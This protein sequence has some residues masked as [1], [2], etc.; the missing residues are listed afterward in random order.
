REAELSDIVRIVGPEALPEDDKLVLEVARMIKED[1]LQQSAYVP[2]DAYSPPEKGHL[3]MKAIILF[4]N[5]AKEAVSRG[6]PVARI[7][8]FKC[9]T[10]IARMKYYTLD[11]LRE[12]VFR[13]VVDTIET[14]FSE[15]LR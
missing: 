12:R 11:E 10:M 9:R 5:K 6:V 3:I 4:Y 7:R 2:T 14:E 15:L 8:E 1:F 13:E